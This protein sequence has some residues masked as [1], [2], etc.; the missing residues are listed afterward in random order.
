MSG[1]RIRL[2]HREFDGF[3]DGRP[4]TLPDAWRQ[5]EGVGNAAILAPDGRLVLANAGSPT[6]RA[7]YLGTSRRRRAAAAARG[8]VHAEAPA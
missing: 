1:Y 8:A 3:R 6:A 2:D 4:F 5:V 7:A